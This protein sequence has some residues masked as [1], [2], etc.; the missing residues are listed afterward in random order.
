ALLLR[1]ASLAQLHLYPALIAGIGL[2]AVASMLIGNLLALMQDNPKRLLAYSS[3]AHMGY[4]LIA[5]LLSSSWAIEAAGLYLAAY[6]LMTLGAFAALSVLSAPQQEPQKLEDL[7]GLLWRQPVAGLTLIVML[8]SLAG[9]PLTIGFVGKFYL[10]AAA[11]QGGFWLLISALIIGSVIGLFYYLRFVVVLIQAEAAP[12]AVK[13]CNLV[14]NT[15][16]FGCVA[17]VL[18]LGVS[19]GSLLAILRNIAASGF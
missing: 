8:L 6:L 13:H 9:I 1:Y 11:V 18:L 14:G 2:L 12:Q 3:I 7:R 4:V 17:L 19:P 5:V 15:L 16:L 10:V